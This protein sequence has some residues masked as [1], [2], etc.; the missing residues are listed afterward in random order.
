MS[1]AGKN[2][3][4]SSQDAKRD[5][6]K[7]WPNSHQKLTAKESPKVAIDE[8]PNWLTGLNAIST[9]PIDLFEID[10]N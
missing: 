7:G 6:A 5:E 3:I 8:R 9:T 2:R 4:Q 10:L 1:W